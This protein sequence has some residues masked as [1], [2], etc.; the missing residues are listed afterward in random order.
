MN[1]AIFLLFIL[2]ILL[3]DTSSSDCDDVVYTTKEGCEEAKDI[4]ANDKPVYTT[5]ESV[6][7][8]KDIHENDK[9]VYWP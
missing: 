3:K 9:S 2:A 5:Q 7:E 4:L 8:G 6:D 1:K